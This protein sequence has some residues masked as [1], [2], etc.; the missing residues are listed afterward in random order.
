MLE[1]LYPSFVFPDKLISPINGHTCKRLLN[2]NIKKFGFESIEFFL[3]QYP[4]FPLYCQNSAK[5]RRDAIISAPITDR[6]IKENNIIDYNVSPKHCQHCD[7]ILNYKQRHN[8][9]CSLSC[10]TTH[11][12]LNMSKKQ[13]QNLLKAQREYA[14]K[15][16]RIIINYCKSCGSIKGTCPKPEICKQYALFFGLHKYFN[17]DL[18]TIGSPKIY[19]EYIKIQKQVIEEY[20]SG[21]S[22]GEMAKK[23]GHPQQCNFHKILKQLGVNFRSLKDCAKNAFRLG[24]RTSPAAIS[25]PFHA[26]WHTTWDNKQVFLRSSYELDYAIYLDNNK[27]IYEVETLNIQYW[28]SQ[29]KSKRTAIPDFY[30]PHSNTIIEI[31]STYTLDLQNMKDKFS[32]YNILGYK[33]ILV[34]NKKEV[35][36]LELLPSKERII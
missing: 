18:S 28:D 32:E 23:Y 2:K 4:N 9:F 26:A 14:I 34:L 35:N 17:F 10:A 29:Q 7:N 33:T 15:H 1:N 6:H 12:N 8:K 16:K 21:S 25:Y 27:I 11:H 30:I 24:R 22:T 13:R 20:N 5:L 31:K 3:H 19:D 36:I